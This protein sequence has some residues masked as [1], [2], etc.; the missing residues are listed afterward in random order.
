MEDQQKTKRQLIRELEESRALVSQLRKVKEEAETTAAELRRAKGVFEALLN[1]TTD[2]AGLVDTEG[3]SLALNQ[4]AAIMLGGKTEDFLG[5]P[6]FDFFP[7]GLAEHRRRKLQEVVRTGVQFREE[8]KLDGRIF[9]NSLWP[10]FGSDG[11]VEAV[12]AF[13]RDIT[14]QR[15]LEKAQE[16]DREARF[17]AF[18]NNGPVIAVLKSEDGRYAYVNRAWEKQ[19][20]RKAEEVLGKHFYEIWPESSA[21]RLKETDREALSLNTTV[22]S[23]EQ[24]VD[25]KGNVKNLWVFKFPVTDSQG[26]RLV[27]GLALD[28]TEEKRAQE[29]LRESEKRFRTVFER[30]P[31]GMVMISLDYKWIA[32]NDT[33]CNMLGYTEEEL[34]RLSFVDITHPDDV[35]VSISHLDKLLAGEISSHRLEKRYI[36]RSGEILWVSLTDALVRDDDSNPMYFIAMIEDITYRIRAEEQIKASLKEKEVLLRE[37]NHRVKNNLQVVS[38]LI[39]L[40]CRRVKDKEALATFYDFQNRVMSMA[41]AHEKLCFSKSLAELDIEVY[42]KSLLGHVLSSFGSAASKISFERDVAPVSLAVDTAIPLGFIITELVSN[43]VKH[44]FPD[45]REGSVRVALEPEGNAFQLMVSDN[46]V[47]IR[48]AANGNGERSLG[49]ELV[50]IFAAQLNGT[51]DIDGQEGTRVTIIFEGSSEKGPAYRANRNHSLIERGAITEQSA[52]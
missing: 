29:A 48:S 37:I 3:R 43:S 11:R 26:R 13:S 1:A 41:I 27:G 52:P 28:V 4:A 38:S 12:A 25:P 21:R 17:H 51:L 16:E 47:G 39:N 5:K 18:M 44:A 6:I 14:E 10:V 23:Y 42:I 15:R 31:V 8:D 7:A 30:G 32:F 24:M 2:V 34:R 9:D 22:E 50:R 40:H 46:G 33:Y 49:L 20:G 36:R 19:F 35:A 45:G